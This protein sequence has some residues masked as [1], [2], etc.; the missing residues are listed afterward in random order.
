MCACNYHITEAVKA[1]SIKQDNRPSRVSKTQ[2]GRLCRIYTITSERIAQSSLLISSEWFSVQIQSS[3]VRA[4]LRT[5]PPF[6]IGFAFNDESKKVEMEPLVQQATVPV[7]ILVQVYFPERNQTL[8]FVTIMFKQRFS[9]IEKMKRTS[10]P[11][12]RSLK[13]W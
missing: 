7:K 1:I 5:I 12:E 10:L 8:T 4:S 6:P 13:I 2:P 9:T 11:L 3:S